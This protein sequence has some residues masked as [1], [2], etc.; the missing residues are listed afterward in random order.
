[1][2]LYFLSAF[3]MNS[4]LAPQ[5][6]A[7]ACEQRVRESSNTDFDRYALEFR[8]N[9]MIIISHSK[10]FIIASF[11]KALCIKFVFFCFTNKTQK[12]VQTWMTF[13]MWLEND[14]REE[15][16]CFWW[17]IGI[18]VWIFDLAYF[19]HLLIGQTQKDLHWFGWNL[20]CVCVL[21][22]IKQDE[23]HFFLD[24][25]FS[26]YVIPLWWWH[27]QCYESCRRCGGVAAVIHIIR[28]VS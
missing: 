25:I 2:C 14:Q 22:P 13:G 11:N 27:Q 24:C 7:L 20:K 16:R 4:F 28:Q 12:S 23:E 8:Q 19:M 3:T 15:L 10:S 18:W 9:C 5:G 26:V 1:M 6:R 17:I 21:K